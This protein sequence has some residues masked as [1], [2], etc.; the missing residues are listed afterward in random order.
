MKKYTGQK[1]FSLIELMI[2]VAIIG[3]LAAIAIPQ[4]NNYIARSQVSEVLNMVEPARSIVEEYQQNNGNVTN[5]ATTYTTAASVLGGTV[6]GKYVAS[7]VG[8]TVDGSNVVLTATFNA[9]GVNTALISKQVK[10]TITPSTSSA[11][12]KLVCAPGDTDPVPAEY[13]PSS[14][15][16]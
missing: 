3:I 6:A 4:Y 14:C 5:F 16:A 2:V 12:A 7:W 1:G 10:I 9:T 13:L 15:T 11:G 8:P